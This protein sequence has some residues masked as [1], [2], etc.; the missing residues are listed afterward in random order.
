MGSEMCIRDSFSGGNFWF[1]ATDKAATDVSYTSSSGAR[2]YA[3]SIG[4]GSSYP[5]TIANSGSGGSW[6]QAAINAGYTFI[7]CTNT[8]LTQSTCLSNNGISSLDEVG[9]IVANNITTPS[10]GH[11]VF[12]NSD[13]ADWINGGGVFHSTMG[14]NGTTPCCGAS[15]NMQAA[16]DLFS[17]LGWGDISLSLIHI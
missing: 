7:D 4:R 12:S 17:E 6:E 5:G 8:S 14:E 11:Y 15:I 10:S 13:L 9:F 3:I 2:T 16:D 1:M